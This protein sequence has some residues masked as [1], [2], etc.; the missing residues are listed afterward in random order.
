MLKCFYAHKEPQ[1]SPLSSG[2]GAPPVAPCCSVMAVKVLGRL[3]FVVVTLYGD[4]RMNLLPVHLLS[5][6]E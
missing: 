5:G 3:S 6:S 2:A 4:N 1:F